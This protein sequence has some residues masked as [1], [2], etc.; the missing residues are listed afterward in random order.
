M[1]IA[2]VYSIYVCVVLTMRCN[3]EQGYENQAA[4]LFVSFLVLSVMTAVTALSGTTPPDPSV[5]WAGHRWIHMMKRLHVIT[6]IG[7]F[8]MEVCC[9]FFSLFALHRVLAGGFDTRASSTA[10]LLVRE[11]EF[12]YVAVCSYFFAGAMLL[13]CPVAIRCFCTVQQGVRSDLLAASVCCLIVGIVLLILSFF[14]AHLSAF[15]Y[16]SYEDL[17]RRFV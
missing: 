3:A 4:T 16:S 8:L 5:H 9:M 14:N 1:F 11:L 15:P 10:A 6:S 2:R 12:E 17:L 13:M 7:C